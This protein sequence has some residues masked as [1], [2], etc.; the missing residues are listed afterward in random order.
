MPLGTLDDLDVSA[1]FKV[2]E[3]L[4][5]EMLGMRRGNNSKHCFKK[6]GQ[7]LIEPTIPPM[8]MKSNESFVKVQSR[9][10]SSVV[11]N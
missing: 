8:W 5:V 10:A 3:G 7:S 11:F 1:G 2:T 4:L 9:S 6:A